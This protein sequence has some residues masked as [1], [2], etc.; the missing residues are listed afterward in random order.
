MR[1]TLPGLQQRTIGRIVVGGLVLFSVVSCGSAHSRHDSSGFV[2]ASGTHLV[3]DGLPFYFAGINADFVPHRDQA[4]AAQ[5]LTNAKAEGF[6]VVRMFG[7]NDTGNPAT[8]GSPI[9]PGYQYWSPTAGGPAYNNGPTPGLRGLD[10]AIYQAHKDRLRVII[11][12]VNNWDYYGGMD[13]YVCWRFCTRANSTGRCAGKCFVGYHDDFYTDPIIVSWYKAWIAHVL[14]HVNFYTGVAY[15][16][17]PTILAWQLANEPRCESNAVAYPRSRSCTP[18]GTILPW[19][20]R[21][22]SYVKSIDPHHL[23]AV[24][25]EGFLCSPNATDSTNNCGDGDSVAYTRVS[26][27]DFM[28]IHDYPMLWNHCPTLSACVRWG[29][30]WIAKHLYFAKLIGKPAVLDEFGLVSG[31]IGITPTQQGRA[32][33]AWTRTVYNDGGAGDM[34]WSLAPSG[35]ADLVGPYG[36]SCPSVSCT[37]LEANATAMR[38]K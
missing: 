10:Y 11:P 22:A 30:A 37:V 27:I 7:F 36:V 3:V 1:L 24:G 35:G 17:D 15:K 20:K 2:T 4:A 29:D 32:Y 8:R 12:L 28:S 25:D 16:N 26:G 19:V 31:H 6:T 5:D 21:M 38:E 23:L 18:D 34:V 13:A 9:T 14:D 33:Q